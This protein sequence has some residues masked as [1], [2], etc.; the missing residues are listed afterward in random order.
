[1]LL[2]PHGEEANGGKTLAELLK[3]LPRRHIVVKSGHTAWTEG[4]VPTLTV[5]KA[6]PRNLYARSCARWARRRSEIEDEI[7]KRHAMIGG[8]PNEALH[9]WE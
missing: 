4:V 7:R 9:D 2:V 8:A 6:D 1:M 5:P 3:N